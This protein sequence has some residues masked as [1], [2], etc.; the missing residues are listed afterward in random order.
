MWAF[1]CLLYEIFTGNVFFDGDSYDKIIES[2]KS[3]C[4]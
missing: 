3:F 1:G 2:I 4:N